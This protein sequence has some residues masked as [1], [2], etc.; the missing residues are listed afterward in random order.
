MYDAL[1]NGLTREN[2]EITFG[3]NVQFYIL[4]IYNTITNYIHTHNN[5]KTY[6]TER[7]H[8]PKLIQPFQFNSMQSHIP[9]V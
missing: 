5:T 6:T 1:F 2:N 3:R 8:S 4:Y 9:I 7:V